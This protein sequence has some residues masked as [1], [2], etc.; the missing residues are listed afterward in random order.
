MSIAPTIEAV[1]ADKKYDVVTCIDVLVLSSVDV[2]QALSQLLELTSDKG[3]LVINVAAFPILY[4]YHDVNCGV[5]RRFTYKSFMELLSNYNVTVENYFYWN[6]LL[7][8]LLL[9]QAML[10]RIGSRFPRMFSRKHSNSDLVLPPFPLNRILLIILAL[11]SLMPT[12]LRRIFGVVSLFN[13][14]QVLIIP[15]FVITFR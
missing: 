1:T 14:A 5:A 10:Y 9:C 2:N 12:F 6:M 13:F 8:P 4:R 3:L 7:S 15:L 11:E